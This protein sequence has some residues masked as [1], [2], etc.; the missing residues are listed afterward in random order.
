MVH[1]FT[2]YWWLLFPLFWMIMGAVGSMS[3]YR[4]KS[5]MLKLLKS[6]ADQ[7]K[8]PPPALLDALKS[9]EGRGYD[10]DDYYARRRYRRYRGG[11]WWWQVVVFASLAA[12]L[13]YAGTHGPFNLNGADPSILTALALA[14]GVAAIALGVIGAIRALFS[15][16]APDMHDD[17]KD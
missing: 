7:G 1:I 11:G 5:D 9:D 16:K 15:P 12:G 10:R 3:H 2:S 14:F 4:H 6:Y 8:D 17:Y 13:G